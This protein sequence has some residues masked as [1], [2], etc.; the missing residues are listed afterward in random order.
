M[1][2]DILSRTCEPIVDLRVDAVVNAANKYLE[3]GGGLCGAIYRGAGELLHA[4]CAQLGG[5]R[6][7][8]VKS[9]PGFN[10]PARYIFHAVGPT[11]DEDV[12]LLASCYRRSLQLAQDMNLRSI[13]FPCIST[14]IYAVD[15]DR[16]ADIA[17]R[18]VC[19][20]L[21]T[22]NNITSIDKVIFAFF[23]RADE[24][25]YIDR[26]SRYVTTPPV[27]MVRTIGA[28]APGPR[29]PSYTGVGV[30]CGR[31]TCA[32]QVATL[33]LPPTWTAP[34]PPTPLPPAGT[35]SGCGTSTDDTCSR[36]PASRPRQGA[37]SA[38]PTSLFH[39]ARTGTA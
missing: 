38:R 22:G 6:T 36:A 25:R 24:Q 3:A 34:L 12:N 33:P 18:T 35:S 1:L 17:M 29:I 2:T 15:P 9:T 31:A 7:G 21:N 16:A 39:H 23:K 8:D 11:A 19:D 30:T 27:A 5:C 32:P 10:L 13:A 37:G 20:W 4:A 26:W 14:G 28:P